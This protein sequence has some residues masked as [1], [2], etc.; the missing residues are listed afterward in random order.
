MI[1]LILLA[2]VE[3]IATTRY[4]LRSS[5]LN[6]F[7]IILIRYFIDLLYCSFTNFLFF[8]SSK[9]SCSNFSISIC[10]RSLSSLPN[11]IFT[12]Y[13]TDSLLL[14]LTDTILLFSIFL[15]ILLLLSLSNTNLLL[16][17]VFENFSN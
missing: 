6:L 4:L 9:Y 2:V 1:I 5:T 16:L 3:S 14:S 11:N 15:H 8:K 10:M 7:H 12:G 17:T 13:S